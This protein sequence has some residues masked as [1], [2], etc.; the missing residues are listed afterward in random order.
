MDD[1]QA[2]TARYAVIY[3]NIV[4]GYFSELLKATEHAHKECNRLHE[5][6]TMHFAIRVAVLCGDDCTFPAQD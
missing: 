4:I 2:E 1:P 5:G 6:G 3:G